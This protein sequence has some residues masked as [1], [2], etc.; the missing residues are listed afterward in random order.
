MWVA[1]F[2]QKWFDFAWFNLSRTRVWSVSLSLLREK[3]TQRI[4]G[5]AAQIYAPRV[6][7]EQITSKKSLEF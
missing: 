5:K 4:S 7:A 2:E 1:M 3:Q 6:S